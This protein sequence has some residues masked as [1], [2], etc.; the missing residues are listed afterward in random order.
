MPTTLKQ[1]QSTITIIHF[2]PIPWHNSTAH[3]TSIG[4][5][6]P[7]IASIHRSTKIQIIKASTPVRYDCYQTTVNWVPPIDLTNKINHT[8]VPEMQQ[9]PYDSTP[10]PW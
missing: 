3:C 5:R 10:S 2:K 6:D 1:L 9:N 8:I 7:S 4:I